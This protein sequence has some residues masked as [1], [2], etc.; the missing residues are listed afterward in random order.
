MAIGVKAMMVLK[1][2]ARTESGARACLTKVKKESVLKR[3]KKIVG[4]RPRF[5]LIE[6]LLTMILM[7]SSVRAT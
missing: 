1:V 6:N 7:L 3:L 4:E 2:R 5:G